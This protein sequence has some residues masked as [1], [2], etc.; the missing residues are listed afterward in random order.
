[1][2]TKTEKPVTGAAQ[3]DEAATWAAAAETLVASVSASHVAGLDFSWRSLHELDQVIDELAADT[4]AISLRTRMNLAAYVGEVLVRQYGGR[5]ASGEHYGQVL[6]PERAVRNPKA[7]SES[8]HPTRMIERRLI[9]GDSIQHQVF[10][11]S[12]AWALEN[13]VAGSTASGDAPAAMMRMAADAFV[14]SAGTNGVNWLDYSAGSALRLDELIG[15]WWPEAPE[16][17]TYESMVPA[18]GAYLGEVL[19]TQTGARWIR[20]P[21]QGYGV[22]FKGQVVYPMIEVSKRFELGPERPIGAF[23]RDVTS[24]WR[25]DTEKTMPPK[26]YEPRTKRGGLFGRG[27]G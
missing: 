2:S 5:W 3:A 24:R 27:R 19:V 20:D 21:A 18:M 11:Q 15:E 17:D 25:W 26:V 14:K 6:P 10:D 23:Y 13:G 12:R 1:M 4:N 16:K 7:K 9:E 22:E 8:A